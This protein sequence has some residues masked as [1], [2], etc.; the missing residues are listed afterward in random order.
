MS[1]RLGG[2]VAL[3]TGAGSVGPGW[4]N[5]RAM[6]VIFAQE[7][8]RVYLVDRDPAALEVTAAQ[9]REAGGE[10]ETR[11][12]D[13]T[14][15]ADVEAFVTGAHERFGAL[16]VLVNNV[17]GSRAG[18]A[19]ELSLDD[20][21][22]Q[23]RVNLTSVFLGC[24]YAIPLMRAAGGGSIVNISSASGLRYTGAPQVAYAS[25]K[26][27]ILQLTRVTAVQY[28][29][30]RVRVNAVVPGQLHTPMVEARLAGQRAGGDV[31]SLLAQRQARIPIGFM[32]DGRDTAYAALF[33]ASDESRFVTGAE[34]VVD[35][36]MSVRCD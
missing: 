31:E 27:A 34:I 3:V 26:A 32:G 22:A 10:V 18:G 20:W 16:D 29:P 6:S 19:V 13:V 1:G 11:L 23:V 15:P 17:G 24:K 35:G 28:A 5:G 4:G 36:G 2:K 7:G 25:T 12:G 21:N 9:A 8:A 30:D 33:L 14:D